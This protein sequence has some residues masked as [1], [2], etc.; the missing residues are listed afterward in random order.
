MQILF[1]IKLWFCLTHSLTRGKVRIEKNTISR[2]F[3][4]FCG[5]FL[6]KAVKSLTRKTPMKI[7]TADKT[8]TELRDS[9]PARTDRTEANRGC[10]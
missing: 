8:L 9:M 7:R 2:K 4:G 6:R 3:L 1:N 5:H 10:R